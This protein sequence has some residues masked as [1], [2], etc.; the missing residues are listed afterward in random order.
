MAAAVAAGGGKARPDTVS[1]AEAMY[2]QGQT[3][4]PNTA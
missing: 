2:I 1:K 3:Q 4:F